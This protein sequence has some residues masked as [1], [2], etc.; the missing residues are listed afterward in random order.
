M[1][2]YVFRGIVE[3][4]TTKL[5]ECGIHLSNVW[6]STKKNRRDRYSGKTAKWFPY[7]VANIRGSGNLPHCQVKWFLIEVR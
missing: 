2:D 5:K 6:H 1:L 7:D 4:R 3:P